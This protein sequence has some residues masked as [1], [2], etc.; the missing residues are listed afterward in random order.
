MLD[1]LYQA[2]L[3]RQDRKL[4]RAVCEA[5]GIA[6]AEPLAT[7]TVDGLAVE[8][9]VLERNRPTRITTGLP[10]SIGFGARTDAQAAPKFGDMWFDA[11]VALRGD[12]AFWLRALDR[13]TRKTLDDLVRF[14]AATL[15]G[16]VLAL[17]ESLLA[18]VMKPT[19][20]ERVAPIRVAVTLAK[21]LLATVE[22]DDD[23][24]LYEACKRGS[25]RER[26]T[27]LTLVRT[28]R[29]GDPRTKA[30]LAELDEAPDADTQML[31][32]LSAARWARV[33]G[34]GDNTRFGARL[35]CETIETLRALYPRVD[36]LPEVV[37][38]DGA[39]RDRTTPI[40]PDKYAATVGPAMSIAIAHTAFYD[41]LDREPAS[42]ATISAA[43][44]AICTAL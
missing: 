22:S 24:A 2:Y 26:L 5:L 6:Y 36:T 33:A 13:P 4:W 1:R 34:N 40:A 30:L 16:G 20:D 32:A 25:Q 19:V 10:G 41:E 9:E 29:A 37:A 11:S 28:Q 42:R 18:S 8:I 15:D 7:G 35:L 14:S 17:R 12:L 43:L 23:S 38:F 31:T 44:K 21:R 27:A 3:R 39:F